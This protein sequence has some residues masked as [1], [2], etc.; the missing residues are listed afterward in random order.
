MYPIQ[1]GAPSWKVELSR[2]LWFQTRY[3]LYLP[4]PSHPAGAKASDR[5][6][7][8]PSPSACSG[9]IGFVRHDTPDA[10]VYTLE[11]PGYRRKDLGIQVRD[12][13]VVVHGERRERFFKPKV[14]HSFVQS[15]TLPETLDAQDIRADLRDSVLSVT[16]AKK[17]E[18]R[19]RRIPILAAD[20]LAATLPSPSDS[21][22]T[23]S[24]GSWWHRV[25]AWCRGD[26]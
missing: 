23:R 24:S 25:S 4:N 3:P 7:H 26:A 19:A 1:H 13:R 14:Q 11:V 22:P 18:A 17:P 10:A 2:V 12:G 15:I 21:A 6:E 16:I 5:A 9:W 20:Q 8:R